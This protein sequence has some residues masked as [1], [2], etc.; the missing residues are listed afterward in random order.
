VVVRPIGRSGGVRL[1]LTLLVR[2]E[3]DVIDANL[4]YHLAAGVDF[5]I[6]TDNRSEDGT[7]R[8]LEAYE[9]RGVLRLIDEPAD[10]YDQAVWVTRMARLAA[11]DH[12]AAWVINSDADEFWWPKRGDLKDVLL[13]MPAEAGA[14]AIPRVNF[15]PSADEEGSFYERL[16]VRETV[17]ANVH[18]D[19]LP[20]KVAHRATRNVTVEQ[21]NHA[22]SGAGLGLHRGP[23]P[24][25]ILHFPLR[26]YA[27]FENKIVKGGMAYERNTTLP[28]AVGSGW[29]MLYDRHREGTLRQY[30]DEQ[31]PSSVEIDHRIGE[32]T[33]IVDRRLACA[34]ASSDASVAP[35]GVV[36]VVKAAP[37][38]MRAP[39]RA[40]ALRPRS[41]LLAQARRTISRGRRVVRRRR[42]T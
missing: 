39:V 19:P 10:N 32:G 8:I 22:V 35:I 5:V 6:A 42:G 13:R 40:A 2:D 7:R 3:E 29:R 23:A 38:T 21:G 41:G 33:L 26:T 9:R 36:R 20:P 11:T 30:Y 27:Q 16:T 15:V 34:L 14:V 1:V 37:I 18:G 12:D 17:S 28:R 31:V 25:T 24:I 4:R